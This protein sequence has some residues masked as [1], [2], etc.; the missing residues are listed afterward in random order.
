MFKDRTD[1]GKQL[2]KSLEKYLDEDVLILAIPRGGVEIGYQVAN[3][4]DAELSLL[5]SRKLPFPYNPEA[6]FGAVTEDGSSFINEI[7]ARE[8]SEEMIE[9]IKKEQVDEIKR[10]IEILRNGESLPDMKGRT[11]IITDDGLAMG[12]TMRASVKLCKNKGAGKIVVAVPVAGKQVA[13]MINKVVDD[14]IVL[15]IPPF[16]HAVAQVYENWYDVS[17]YEVID[18]MNKAKK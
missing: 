13:D 17:D 6:G 7:A 10:R 15:D 4:L 9:Q 5:I 12:S 8:L 2:A 1:A 16:F 14:I 11:V 18:I 3:Y